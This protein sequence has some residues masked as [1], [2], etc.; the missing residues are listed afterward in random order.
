MRHVLSKRSSMVFKILTFSD[1]SPPRPRP[2][3]R[4]PQNQSTHPPHF[5]RRAWIGT[6]AYGSRLEDYARR[7]G[8][9][10]GPQNDLA[11]WWGCGRCSKQGSVLEFKFIF[12]IDGVMAW[13]SGKY[14]HLAYLH[15][16]TQWCHRLLL[17][18]TIRGWPISK[19]NSKLQ[20]LR[21]KD[22]SWF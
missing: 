18:A 8:A 11:W 10:R 22:K 1:T 6:W 20:A 2:L 19:L 3:H 15:T 9:R 5:I 14:S 7:P 12:L 17:Y 21:P 13:A 16:T 4:V